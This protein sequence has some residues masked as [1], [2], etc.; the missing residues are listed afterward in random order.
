MSSGYADIAYLPAPEYPDIPALLIEL[1]YDK[2]AD[3]AL[4]QIRRQR[5]PQRLEHYKGNLLLVA[6]DYDRELS[7]EN[8]Q[9][10]H[11]TCRIEE[12]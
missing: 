9:F 3:T 1:K 5:Y 12:A 8:E 4:A 10:K 6:I 7:N 2:T 11:H